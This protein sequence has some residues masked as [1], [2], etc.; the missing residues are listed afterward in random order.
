MPP[1]I[2]LVRCR[3][4]GRAAADDCHFSAASVPGDSRRHPAVAESRLDDIELI[5]MD[6]D[7][8]AVHPANACFFTERRTHP[9]CEL[10]EVAGLEESGQRVSGVIQIYLVV[11]LRDHVVQ[12]A[13]CDHT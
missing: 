1:V 5:V 9:A 4:S 12:G 13:S 8:F 7:R 11:P 10:R 6:R 2:E 3:K